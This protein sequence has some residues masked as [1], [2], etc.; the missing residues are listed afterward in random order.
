VGAA[1]AGRAQYGLR[2]TSGRKGLA[3]QVQTVHSG[4]ITVREQDILTFPG[5]I[6]GFEETTRYVLLRS[7]R[8]GLAVLQAV[9]AGPAFAVLDTNLL[10][11]PYVLQVELADL[12][13]LDVRKGDPVHSYLLITPAHEEKR[14]TV[15]MLAPLAVNARARLGKQLVQWGSPLGLRYDL[16]AWGCSG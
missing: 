12:L 11:Q 14:L 5:G 9:P 16:L 2:R 13:E 1:G 10:P 3:V 8:P 6:I 4:T 15:N 7:A